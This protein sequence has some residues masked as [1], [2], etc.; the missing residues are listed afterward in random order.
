M[1]PS[2]ILY[3]LLAPLSAATFNVN[4]TADA[5]DANPGNGVCA[6]A[7][8][9]NTCTLRAAI[10]ESNALAG[11]DAVNVPAGNYSLSL[12]ALLVTGNVRVLG[13][14]AGLARVDGQ[15]L[16]R[17][18]Q[19]NSGRVELHYLDIVNGLA[20]GG[21]GGG[22][23]N[24]R[25]QVLIGKCRVRS[26]RADTGGAGIHNNSAGIVSI[27]ESTIGTNG[28][29]VGG[30]A[31]PQRGG[32]IQNNGVL[33][34]DRSSI[35]G[36]VAGRAGGIF[37]GGSAYLIMR[38]STVS[39][40]KADIDTGG[41]LNGGTAYLNNSTVAFNQGQVKPPAI[42]GF[43]PASAGGISGGSFH[44]ANTV[45]A[46]NTNGPG[47]GLGTNLDCG[48]NITSAGHNL[49]LETAGCV[50]GGDLTGNLAGQDPMLQA[51]ALNDGS[52]MNHA[53]PA[54]SVA[55][56]A[57]NPAAP[58]G[59]SNHCE[60][61]DQRYRLRGVGPAVGKCDIGSHER[62]GM[63]GQVGAAPGPPRP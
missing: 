5:A 11:D 19:V 38:N 60:P 4:S 9:S 62:N 33:Y 49:V 53:L 26:N 16:S 6:I 25:G 36:N 52:T 41:I 37:G 34:V 12:G 48:G 21:S 40:N 29:L 8:Q 31:K 58:D 47:T 30:D 14:V 43:D 2:R 42:D 39:G 51:L 44:I 45:L 15:L 32:G 1:K 18:F 17:V 59:L 10:E 28:H 57:G 54:G 56:N 22:V 23:F 55:V 61:V 20:L 24:D 50:I 7:G 13:P 63:P 27:E 3:V 46:K 35:Y